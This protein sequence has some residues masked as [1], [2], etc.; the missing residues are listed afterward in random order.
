MASAGPPLGPRGF[1]RAHVGLGGGLHADEAREHRAQRARHERER[2][3]HADGD[4]EEDGHHHDESHEDRVLPA[5]EGHRARVDGSG[6]L[7]H[8]AR[9]GRLGHHVAVQ[10]EGDQEADDT[11]G[12]REDGKRHAELPLEATRAVGFDL[13]ECLGGRLDTGRLHDG[14]L[15]RL[16]GRQ[17]VIHHF[18]AGPLG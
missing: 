8:G 11:K 10:H 17:H 3:P 1:G 6:D 14:K 12:R 15:V 2:R 5:E 7:D 9:A 16:E 4:G 13:F 18:F